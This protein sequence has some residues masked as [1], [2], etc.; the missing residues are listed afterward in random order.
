VYVYVYIHTS[1]YF[2]KKK[3]GSLQADINSNYSREPHAT[4]AATTDSTTSEATTGPSTNAS[5]AVQW[6]A[7]T[8]GKWYEPDDAC[9]ISSHARRSYGSTSKSATTS[10]TAATASGGT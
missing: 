8:D 9:A 3:I 5:P 10:S 6:Y 2:G 1:A 4:N 7:S